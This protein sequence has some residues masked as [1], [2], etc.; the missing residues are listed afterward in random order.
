MLETSQTAA[1][2]AIV[3]ALLNRD[4]AAMERQFCSAT[5]FRALIPRGLREAA[6]ASEAAGYFKTWF[7]DCDVIEPLD[8][9]FDRIADRE[10]VRYRLKLREDG[11]WYVCEQ[12]IYANAGENGIE[13]MDLL[14]SGFRPVAQ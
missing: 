10:C 5:Q 12:Q 1:L 6:T 14:C 13:R 2:R 4:F 3:D 11:E 9:R 8:I 7:A